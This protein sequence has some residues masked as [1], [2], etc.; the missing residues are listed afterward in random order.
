MLDQ[1][2]GWTILNIKTNST[3]DGRGGQVINRL[4]LTLQSLDGQ[5][6]IVT[7]AP[8]VLA[9]QGEAGVNFIYPSVRPLA[10]QAI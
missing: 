4:E 2:I 7:L 3:H 9:D 8:G 1:F 6:K 10:Q 5:R